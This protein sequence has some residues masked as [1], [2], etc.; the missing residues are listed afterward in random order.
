MVL[1]RSLLKVMRVW[2]EVRDKVAEDSPLLFPNYKGEEVAHLSRRVMRYAE[3]KS[4]TLVKPQ[5]LRTAVELKGKDL[6]A[7]VQE[8]L[9]RSLT[10][11]H[12]EKLSR[13]GGGGA[14][15]EC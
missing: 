13:G 1:S 5:T 14:K 10:D 9:T 2:E 3:T 8:A 12:L 11:F 15:V 4:I 7:P 6:P